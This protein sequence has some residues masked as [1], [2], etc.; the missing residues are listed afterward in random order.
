MENN[1]NLKL[2]ENDTIELYST[3]YYIDR[4][5]KQVEDGIIPLMEV[6][7]IVQCIDNE[8]DKYNLPM[9]AITNYANRWSIKLGKFCNVWYNGKYCYY[10]RTTRTTEEEQEEMR[11]NHKRVRRTKNHTILSHDLAKHFFP[12]RSDLELLKYEKYLNETILKITHH[13]DVNKIPDDATQEELRLW[14]MIYNNVYNTMLQRD[15]DHKIDNN[16]QKGNNDGRISFD[17]NLNFIINQIGYNRKKNDVTMNDG[18]CFI[19]KF[20]EGK[21]P[22]KGIKAKTGL[23]NTD[24]LSLEK[25]LERFKENPVKYIQMQKN[26]IENSINSILEE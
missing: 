26:S 12:N 15:K 20:E 22:N 17:S 18:V 6:E 16:L 21:E 14:N 10:T 5:N 19:Y 2:N 13:I 23:N 3:E 24:K 9:W 8:D 4:F 11:K 7:E 1:T 25:K